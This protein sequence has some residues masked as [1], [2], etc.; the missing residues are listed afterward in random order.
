MQDVLYRS[1]LVPMQVLAPGGICAPPE[2]LKCPALLVLRVDARASGTCRAR[3]TIVYTHGNATDLG[4]TAEE[5]KTLSRELECHVIVLEYPGYGVAEGKPTEDTI[6]AAMHAAIRLATDIL[7]TPTDRIVLYGRSV[8]TG[9]AAAAAARLSESQAGPPAALILHS[10][11]TSIQ[12]FACEKAG[13]L[14]S[15]YLRINIISVSFFFFANVHVHN[16][17]AWCDDYC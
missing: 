11:F 17:R 14:V 2:R 15:S 3:G 8:G 10:P 9:P 1:V 13:F 12:D 7:G 5:A 4:G 16:V 6:D